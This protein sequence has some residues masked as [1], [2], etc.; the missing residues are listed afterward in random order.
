ME[1]GLRARN[2][3]ANHFARKRASISEHV[4]DILQNNFAIHTCSFFSWIVAVKVDRFADI[5]AELCR[6]E[7]AYTSSLDG[8]DEAY[9]EASLS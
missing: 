3:G 6:Y 4:K 7:H 2:L 9:N 5:D 8:T 1:R